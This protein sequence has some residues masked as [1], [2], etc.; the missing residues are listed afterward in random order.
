MLDPASSTERST[1]RQVVAS[2]G[3]GTLATTAGCGL[4]G[5]GDS[6]PTPATVP[7][8]LPLV[9]TNR[10]TDAAF[11]RSRLSGQVPKD[12][13]PVRVAVSEVDDESLEETELFSRE[14]T[15]A[16]GQ[17]RRWDAAL[18]VDRSADEYVL[19]GTIAPEIGYHD[20]ILR[21]EPDEIPSRVGRELDVVMGLFPE[22][23]GSNEFYIQTE[24]DNTG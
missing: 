4:L 1:R 18:E 9:F 20:S 8:S 2:L 12:A 15:V 16:V 6:S 7:G 17:N 13:I 24:P 23:P 14:F 11:E 21:F 3:V 19:K 5:G 10:V 22:I